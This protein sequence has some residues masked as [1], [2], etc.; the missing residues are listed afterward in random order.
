MLLWKHL[1]LKNSRTKEE[2]ILELRKYLGQNYNDNTEYQNIYMLQ[3][4][5]LMNDLNIHLK[6]SVQ[7][8]QKKANRT[9]EIR[10]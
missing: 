1:L 2:I 9:E 5:N 6:K 10:K 4:S 8:H 7:E 3:K